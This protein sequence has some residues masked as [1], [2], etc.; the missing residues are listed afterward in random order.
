MLDSDKHTTDACTVSAAGLGT[1]AHA[2]KA[3][4]PVYCTLGKCDDKTAGTTDECDEA[5]KTCSRA[6]TAGSGAAP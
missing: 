5:T 3:V 1:C 2:P 4:E 6:P